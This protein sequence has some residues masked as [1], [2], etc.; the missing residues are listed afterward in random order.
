VPAC[1]ASVDEAWVAA[2]PPLCCCGDDD[3]G[4]VWVEDT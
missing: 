4:E 2:Q 1:A 3:G